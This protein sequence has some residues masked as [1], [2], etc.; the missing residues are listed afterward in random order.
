MVSGPVRKN[1]GGVDV[2]QDSCQLETTLSDQ[3]HG[4]TRSAATVPNVK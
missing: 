2:Q 3:W 4:A 1:A